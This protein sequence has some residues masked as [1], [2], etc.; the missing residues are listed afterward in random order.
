M[1]N[2]IVTAH[3]PNGLG[4]P[5][6]LSTCVFPKKHPSFRMYGLEA[7]K[8]VGAVLTTATIAVMAFVKSAHHPKIAEI[9]PLFLEKLPDTGLMSEIAKLTL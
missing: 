3:C 9:G 5:T 1:A 6:L 4:F 8:S 2:I 7:L